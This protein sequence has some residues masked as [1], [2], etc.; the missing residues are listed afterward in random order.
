MVITKLDAAERQI[1]AAVQL[2]FSGGDPVAVYALAAAARE[3]TTTLC[4]KRGLPS[5]I[6]AMHDEHP[7]MERAEIIQW[8]TKHANFFRGVDRDA[9]GGL[10]GFEDTYADDILFIAV[11]DFGRLRGSKPVEADAYELWF[12]AMRGLLEVLNLEEIE[13]L[14]GITT[15][16]RAAQIQMGRKFL[17]EA[18]KILLPAP[19]DDDEDE[20]TTAFGLFNFAHSY[21]RAAAAL[22]KVEVK[23]SHPDD[24]LWFLYCHAVEL[25]LKAFLRTHGASARE[26]RLRYGHSVR[27]L[28]KA[29]EKVGLQLSDEQREVIRCMSTLGTSLRYIRIGSFT[30]PRLDALART[31][32]SFYDATA[33]LLSSKGH[34][35]RLYPAD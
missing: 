15:A 31:C 9:D 33:R 28:A 27:R 19:I 26:L 8:A 6:D 20:R 29:S 10:E 34:K 22:E 35:I 2:L 18:R 16:S 11:F 3:L 1:V 17:I 32:K 4:E 24:P 21:W 14:N 12:F 13:E 25:F 5:L 30:R 23:A 7:H